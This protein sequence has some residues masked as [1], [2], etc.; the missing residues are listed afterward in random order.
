MR[1]KQS[2]L[3][4][5]VLG[6]SLILSSSYS[7]AD[8]F[9]NPFQS[10][11]AIAQGNAFKAQ[12]D[13]P[14]AIHYN[15][16]GM[17]QLPGIQFSGGFQFIS[18]HIEFKNSAGMTTENDLPAGIGL[19]PP[20]Q[21]F[22]T[23]NLQDFGIHSFG[24]LVVG[25]GMENLFGFATK[26][27]QGSP[28][29]TSLISAELPLLDIKPTV[30]YQLSDWLS[31]GIGADIFTFASFLAEGHAERRFIGIGQV[32]GTASG[33]LLEL[34]GTGT[35]AGMNVSF[36][37]T[38]FRTASGDPLASLGFIWRS[39]AVLPL[40]GSLLVNGAK[41]AD[42]TSSIRFPE[43]YEW[44]FAVWPLQNDSSTWKVE[45]DVEWVRWSSIRDF[46]TSLSTGFVI[47]NPQQLDDTVNVMIG[48][49]YTWLTLPHHPAWSLALRGGY[50]H[51]GQAIPD[52][53]FDPAITDARVNI[54]AL[55]FGL[56]CH[57]G[58]FIFGL[59]PCDQSVDGNFSQ[60]SMVIDFSYQALFF[61][62]RTI[63]GNPNPAV[64]G[65]YKFFT[66]GWGFNITTYFQ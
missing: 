64:N 48:T 20:G 46:N 51:A 9:R 21:L 2:F 1:R 44:G 25:I 65:N 13:D 59:I 37:L 40:N 60:R 16:A 10:S 49:E 53:N 43:S 5:S 66:Q 54:L 55:G 30:A 33:D 11:T 8:G 50:H 7:W 6:F 28:L 27:P 61:E 31:V 24:N 23:A 22:L 63:V 38:P 47:L 14:S 41:L 58:G 45:M 15:P 4:L 26:Y 12:A 52:R 19:P 57:S 35:T 17:T 3:L 42:A 62:P 39:Q 36:L 34:N 32:P 56:G 18:P 29:Q